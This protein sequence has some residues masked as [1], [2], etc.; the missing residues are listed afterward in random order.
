MFVEK[1]CTFLEVIS[2]RPST[3][4]FGLDFHNATGI[5]IDCTV[6][7]DQLTQLVGRVLRYKPNRTIWDIPVVVFNRKR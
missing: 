3:E 7:S 4:M 5:I 2:G 1:V 6:D